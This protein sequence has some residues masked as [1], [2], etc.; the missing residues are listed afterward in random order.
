[1][2][3][4]LFLLVPYFSSFYAVAKDFLI[5]EFD[6]Q[7]YNYFDNYEEKLHNACISMQL[8]QDISH[9]IIALLI[10]AEEKK[11]MCIDY[12]DNEIKM[13]ITTTLKKLAVFAHLY[14]AYKQSGSTENFSTW[15]QHYLVSKSYL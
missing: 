10:H 7:M 8:P 14:Q 15:M 9:A 13:Q 3:L 4:F 1:M 2:S 12:T 11:E 5:T 6:E